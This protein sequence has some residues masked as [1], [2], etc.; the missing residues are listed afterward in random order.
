MSRPVLALL[1]PLAATG[2]V[3]AVST[4][5]HAPFTAVSVAKVPF[6][7]GGKVVDWTT[8]SPSERDRA[9][10]RKK[11]KEE[12]RERRELAKR[13]HKRSNVSGCGTYTGY[14]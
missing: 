13:C 7:A 5:A 3:S 14:T 10:V 11:R 9:Y 8:T 2:C 6:K 4:V 12:E 1:L